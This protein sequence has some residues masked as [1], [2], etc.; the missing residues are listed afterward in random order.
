[1]RSKI[2][3]ASY[4][5]R[6]TRKDKAKLFTVLKRVILILLLAFSLIFVYVWLNIA[7][8]RKGYLLSARQ[9]EKKHL[10]RKNKELKLKVSELKSLERIE[11]IARGK[12]KLSEPKES[13]IVWIER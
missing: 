13:E 7:V 2:K 1:M 5:K 4:K 11:K 6:T 9:A 10:E 3:L 8:V 12:L